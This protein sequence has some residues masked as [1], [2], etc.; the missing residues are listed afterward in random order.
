ME[1]KRR[2]AWGGIWRRLWW[3]RRNNVGP[4]VTFLRTPSLRDYVDAPYS[5]AHVFD[6]ID[7]DVKKK[8]LKGSYIPQPSG[9]DFPA[10]LKDNDSWFSFAYIHYQLLLYFVSLLSNTS[11]AY[12]TY[13]QLS[14]FGL[15]R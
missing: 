1:E 2:V 11:S 9:E 10:G 6:L 15:I 8:R 5:A 7:R 4:P 3:R 13:V 12:T 14:P